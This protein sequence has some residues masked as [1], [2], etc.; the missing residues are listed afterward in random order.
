[1]RVI[2][3]GAADWTDAEAIARELVKL[4]PAPP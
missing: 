4:P 3:A 2:V 1:M